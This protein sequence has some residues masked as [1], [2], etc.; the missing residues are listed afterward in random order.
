MP[1]AANAGVMPPDGI[2]NVTNL[3]DLHSV[4]A[5]EIRGATYR[6]LEAAGP[7]KALL[8]NGAALNF[9]GGLA[10]LEGARITGAN[11]MGLS[12]IGQPV[13]KIRYVSSGGFNEEL[14]ATKER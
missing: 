13:I 7:F 8:G 2:Y 14:E 4:G 12:K 11:Y 10:G 5:L 3:G 6:G 9:S 1:P